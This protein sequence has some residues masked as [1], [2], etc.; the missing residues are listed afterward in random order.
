MS[1]RAANFQTAYMWVNLTWAPV[2][3][4][5]TYPL[6]VKSCSVSCPFSFFC[7]FFNTKCGSQVQKWVSELWLW[8][9]SLRLAEISFLRM[10]CD[11]VS[12]HVTFLV[13][14]SWVFSSLSVSTWPEDKRKHELRSEGS[15]APVKNILAL[16]LTAIQWWNHWKGN[17]EDQQN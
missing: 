2:C 12:E 7:F 1:T 11:E 16:S 6:N 13:R 17:M 14:I 5:K 15:S 9:W 3:D 10:C 8:L 4:Y